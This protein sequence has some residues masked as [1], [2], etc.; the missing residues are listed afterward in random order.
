VWRYIGLR[1]LDAIPT[2][3]LVLTLVFVAMRILPGDPAEVV[4]GELATQAQID[5]MRI[6]MGIDGPLWMQYFAFLKDVATFDFGKSFISGV[7][8]RNILLQNLPY[9]I[10]LTIL[11]TIFGLCLGIPLGVLSARL[12]GTRIDFTSRT[13][14]L[15]GYAV[16]DF[17]LGALL[18]IWL[19]LDLNLFPI[20]GGG[21]G[22][23][24]RLDHLILPAAALAVIKA[25]FISR[26]TRGALLEILGRD[27]I[28]TARAKGAKEPRVVYRHGMH[29]ALLPVSTGLA[30][31]ILSTL[32]GSVAIELVFNR[33]GVGNMLVDAIGTRDYPIV[34]GGLVVFALFVVAVNLLMDIVNIVIDPRIKL[35]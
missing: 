22:F 12:R 28:R 24:D 17:Y 30:L 32:S 6:K 35:S 16:P 5:A 11:A 20:G 18:L 10:E 1:I 21:T 34:Q 2:V 23:L 33:P 7:P 9:T 27:Y 19:S 25:A 13:F 3:L 26:L 15:I 29:N 14:M 4:L 8:V 31:S